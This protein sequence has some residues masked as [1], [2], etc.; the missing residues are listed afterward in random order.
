MAEYELIFEFLQSINMVLVGLMIT[1][2]QNMNLLAV[3]ARATKVSETAFMRRSF[4][5]TGK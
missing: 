2:E 3:S 5:C 4:F 1:A